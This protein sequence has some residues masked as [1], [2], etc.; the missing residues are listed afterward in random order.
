MKIKLKTIYAILIFTFSISF[1]FAPRIFAQKPSVRN[2][3]KKEEQE[4]LE[5]QKFVDS[6]FQYLEDTKDL[7]RVPERFF[8][9][10]FRTRFAKNI[11][12]FSESSEFF[13][14]LS[15]LERY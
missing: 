8:A 1:I 2:E 13:K 10:D 5:V 4:K 3:Q 9:H 14:Q 7:N 11:S 6:F 15:D 12:W